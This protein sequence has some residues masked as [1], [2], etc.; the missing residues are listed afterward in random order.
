MN[1]VPKEKRIYL[2]R[3]GFNAHSHRQ[4]RRARRGKKVMNERTDGR[5][6]R[7][8]LMT[9]YVKKMLIAPIRFQFNWAQYNNSERN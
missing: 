1:A 2:E 3:S 7:I 9:G 6:S 8:G 4:H 5:R